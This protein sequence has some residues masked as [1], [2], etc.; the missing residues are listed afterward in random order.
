MTVCSKR[1]TL[2]LPTL[3]FA[4]GLIISYFNGFTPDSGW[5]VFNST[6][7][8]M[9]LVSFWLTKG[10]ARN[11]KEENLIF[12]PPISLLVALLAYSL[13]YLIQRAPM[14]SILT[15]GMITWTETFNALFSFGAMLLYI[16]RNYDVKVKFTDIPKAEPKHGGMMR[17]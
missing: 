11:V 15:G 12:M 16:H 2:N 6:L 17:M 14:W 7:G 8:V 9:A 10:Y 13:V 4:F 3:F 1:F 5:L